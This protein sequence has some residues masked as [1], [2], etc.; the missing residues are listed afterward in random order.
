MLIVLPEFIEP[1]VRSKMRLLKHFSLLISVTL[2]FSAQNSFSQAN[3]SQ[4]QLN[5]SKPLTNMS[6]TK[7]D[8]ADAVS[9]THLTLPTKA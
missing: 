8:I 3:N 4:G 9:Y 2:L 6:L 5:S 1:I 7:G